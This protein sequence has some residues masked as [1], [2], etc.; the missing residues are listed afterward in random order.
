VKGQ[1]SYDSRTTNGAIW[2]KIPGM[3]G[4]LELRVVRRDEGGGYVAGFA[5]TSHAVVAV[6]GHSR[7]RSAVLASSDATHFVERATPRPSGLHDALVV[8]DA[9]WVCGEDGQ[10]AHSRD[11]GDTW[12]VLDTGTSHCLFS[13]ALATDGAIWVVGAR[14]YAARVLGE[15]PH[16]VELGTEADLRAAHAVS[17]SAAAPGE[18]AVLDASGALRRWSDGRVT[19]IATGASKPLNAL[20]ITRHGT[21]IVVGD[22][23]FLA[24]SPD[25]ARFSQVHLELPTSLQGVVALPAAIVVVGCGGVVLV[26]H[27]DGH[28]WRP[29][30]HDLG[31]THLRSVERL[32]AGSSRDSR[33]R[34]TRL[35]RLDRTRTVAP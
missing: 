8:G 27:D 6:G 30:S 33:R 23:G 28:T 13:L 9:L 2:F 25:G 1:I 22:D 4:E 26:S 7:Q 24:R 16:R 34:G 18:L 12:T 35:G 14:G 21:W 20:A 19:T 31:P 32:G 29:I 3:L 17:T 5:V 15:L 11:Q 10:L